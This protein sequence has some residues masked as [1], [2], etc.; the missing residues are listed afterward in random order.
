MFFE[1]YKKK[2]DKKL[3]ITFFGE[4]I[5]KYRVRTKC[6]AFQALQL[7]LR[8]FILKHCTFL[9]NLAAKSKK[10]LFLM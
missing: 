1:I 7:C 8:N 5:S 2:I 6:R 3:F 10:P 9:E 4:K